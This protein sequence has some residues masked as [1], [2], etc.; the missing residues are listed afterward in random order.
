MSFAI[1]SKVLSEGTFLTKIY[2]LKF[3]YVLWV[4]QVGIQCLL[5]SV[6]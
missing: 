3:T 1:E 5:Y 6:E 4:K 2:T